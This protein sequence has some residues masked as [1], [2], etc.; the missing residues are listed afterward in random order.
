MR[1]DKKVVIITGAWA[2]M[3]KSAAISFSGEGAYVII[4]DIDEETLSSTRHEIES[5]GGT[6]TAITGDATKSECADS[7]TGKALKDYGRVDILFNYVG[8]IPSGVS[9]KSFIDTAE[10]T[11]DAIFELNLK[12]PMLFTRRCWIA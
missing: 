11:W 12:S 2:G 8:G 9:S 4:N 5:A 10:S 6:V 1:F 3:G 7:V